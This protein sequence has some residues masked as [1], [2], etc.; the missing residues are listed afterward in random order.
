MMR[1][2]SEYRI[3][4]GIFYFSIGFLFQNLAFLV[5]IKRWQSLVEANNNIDFQADY[6]NR[7]NDI[8]MR[9]FT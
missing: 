6:G 7:A 2:D 4:I 8:S 9:E 5:N 1:L 3:M